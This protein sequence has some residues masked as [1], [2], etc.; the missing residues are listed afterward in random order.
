M[1]LRMVVRIR[2]EESAAS[3]RGD[4]VVIPRVGVHGSGGGLGV[5]GFC[6][7]STRFIVFFVDMLVIGDEME[8]AKRLFLSGAVG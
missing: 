8:G 6:R 1:I 4:G 7:E 2:E 3:N 5:V